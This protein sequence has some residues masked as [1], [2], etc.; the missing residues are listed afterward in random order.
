MGIHLT[1]VETWVK[2]LWDKYSFDENQNLTHTQVYVSFQEGLECLN[3]KTWDCHISF[4]YISILAPHLVQI[5]LNAM[6]M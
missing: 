4:G 1:L 2:P 3:I 5:N 6:L